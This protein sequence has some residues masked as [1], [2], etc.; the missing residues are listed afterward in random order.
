MS[1]GL[2]SFDKKNNILVRLK[3]TASHTK[4]GRGQYSS[5]FPCLMDLRKVSKRKEIPRRLFPVNFLV[6]NVMACPGPSL[7]LVVVYMRV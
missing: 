2:Q 5:L 7:W 4:Q 3:N 1:L 6:F